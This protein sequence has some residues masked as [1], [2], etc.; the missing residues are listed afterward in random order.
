MRKAALFV[1]ALVALA[2]PMSALAEGEPARGGHQ[3][4]GP[5]VVTG[6]GFFRGEL[7]MRDA[8]E[9]RP[10]VIAGRRGYVGVLALSDDVKV[11]CSGHGEATKKETEKGTVWFCKGLRGAMKIVGSHFVFR[12]FANRYVIALPAGSG[13]TLHGR[14]Q[15]GGDAERG[16]RGDRSDRGESETPTA[17]AQPTATRDAA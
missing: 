17:T 6:H 12:G 2:L 7:E 4:K 8:D 10:V 5:L 9:S 3:V 11:R 15:R 16:D 13:G 14:F 1:I